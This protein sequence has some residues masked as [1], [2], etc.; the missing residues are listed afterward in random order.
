MTNDIRSRL[1]VICYALAAALVGAYLYTVDIELVS[2]IGGA[3]LALAGLVLVF[4]LVGLGRAITSG[5]VE[6]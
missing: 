3:V 2:A 5:R 1:G 4:A 6:P